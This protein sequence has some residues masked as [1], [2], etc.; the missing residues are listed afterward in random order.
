[1]FYNGILNPGVT[2]QTSQGQNVSSRILSHPHPPAPQPGFQTRLTSYSLFSGSDSQ[3][4]KDF[5]SRPEV[6]PRILRTSLTAGRTF[7]PRIQ[8]HPNI[9]PPNSQHLTSNTNVPIGILGP[10]LLS[11]PEFPW[12][13]PDRPPRSPGL[14]QRKSTGLLGT[15]A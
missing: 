10:D 15:E 4:P 11:T 8:S 14:S 1:M 9:L 7:R 3:R 5:Q 2:R 6:H 13:H 12:R